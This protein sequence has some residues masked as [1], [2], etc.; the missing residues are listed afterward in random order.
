MFLNLVWYLLQFQLDGMS[1]EDPAIV[2]PC[3]TVL[4]N[5]SSTVYG[6]L[7]IETQ[8]TFIYLLL[9]LLTVLFTSLN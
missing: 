2:R 9:V 1:S 8:V 5:L 3:V 6:G 7:K 4:R